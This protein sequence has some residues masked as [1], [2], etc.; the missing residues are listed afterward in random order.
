VAFI[1][2]LHRYPTGVGALL[3][4]REAFR[5]LRKKY[6]GGGTVLAAVP[7]RGLTVL[8]EEVAMRLFRFALAV[9]TL[10]LL[11]ATRKV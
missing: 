7:L 11:S 3:G 10:T 9:M 5:I 8:R 1:P 6:F 4:R 2:P